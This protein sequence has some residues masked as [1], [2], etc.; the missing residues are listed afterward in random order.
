ML[1]RSHLGQRDQPMKF[2]HWGH[3]SACLF[4][5]SDFYLVTKQ[6]RNSVNERRGKFLREARL[7]REEPILREVKSLI[8]E[9]CI[10]NIFLHRKFLL[11]LLHVNSSVSLMPLFSCYCNFL[12]TIVL[13]GTQAPTETIWNSDL[14]EF[15]AAQQYNSTN[16][17]SLRSQNRIYIKPLTLSAQKKKEEDKINKFK[18]LKHRSRPNR[19][20]PCTNEH[21]L[22]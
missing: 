15:K 4:L 5:D 10:V 19:G 9:F 20:F 1:L 2:S 17:W 14:N 18:A 11:E 3:R 12:I 8:S 6:T 22:Q 13:S 21:D 7:G 16:N